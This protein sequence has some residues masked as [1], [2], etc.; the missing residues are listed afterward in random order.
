MPRVS[1][2]LEMSG[3]EEKFPFGPITDPRPG[4]TLDIDVAAPDME[5]MKSRPV[6]ES[7]AVIKKK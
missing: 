5:V 6:N 4:P 3:S 1:I 2:H 7:N